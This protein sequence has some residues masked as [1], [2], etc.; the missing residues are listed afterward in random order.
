MHE[1]KEIFLLSVYRWIFTC[2]SKQSIDSPPVIHLD[3][4]TSPAIFMLDPNLLLRER[5]TSQN[6]ILSS[7]ISRNIVGNIMTSSGEIHHSAS[8]A[9]NDDD[10]AVSLTWNKS[11]LPC[12]MG[13]RKCDGLRPCRLVLIVYDLGARQYISA[14]K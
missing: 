8:T 13:K 14:K 6:D 4:T 7:S 10:V 3:L 1:S 2:K 5:D 11:C 9:G 12:R